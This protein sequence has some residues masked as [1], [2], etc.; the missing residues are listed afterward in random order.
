MGA[1]GDQGSNGLRHRALQL[2]E[3]F[4]QLLAQ[5]SSKNVIYP[6]LPLQAT[7]TLLT[8]TDSSQRPRAWRVPHR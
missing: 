2:M 8:A 6:F 5:G 4:T 1:I 7:S 3:R